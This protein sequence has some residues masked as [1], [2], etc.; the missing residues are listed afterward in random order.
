V[1]RKVLI[2][3]RGEIAL[4]VARA[5]RELG[6]P[7]VAVYSTV[8]SASAVVR[9][10]DEAIHVGPPPAKQSYLNVPNVI[11]AALKAGAD[12]IHPGYGFLSEDA[13]FAEICAD[14]GLTFIGPPPSVMRQVGDKAVVRAHMAAAGL[15]VVRGSEGVVGNLTDAAEAAAEIGFPLV[16]KATMGGGGRGIVR[17]D[18]PADLATGFTTTTATAQALFGDPGVYMEKF[19]ADAAH[20]EAQ[21]LADQHGNVHYLGERDCTMQRRNQKLVEES[22]SPRLSDAQRAQL[23]EYA[24]T[25]A[26]SLGYQGAGTL[27]FLADKAGNLTFMEINGRIQV[28]HPVSELV[29]G[30]DIVA[31]MIRGAGG[32]PLTYRP[33]QLATKGCAI[34][35]RINAE[36]PTRDFRPTPGVLTTF[37]PPAGPFVRV[38]SGYVQGDSVPAHYDSL[39]AKVLVHAPD[40]PTAIRR[41]V[42][43]LDE[44][45]VESPSVLTTIGLVRSLVQHPVFVAGE[46]T[47]AFVDR[48]MTEWRPASS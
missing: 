16:I 9:Y 38:D 11:E 3:N 18:D 45:R 21:I 46:H 48:F 44:F 20:V 12:S 10:A 47:T 35:V 2:A 27:E 31:D 13:D 15:P 26:R 30:I 37:Q 29:T 1:L 39:L 22:P 33:D 40:R 36:D 4:R 43:A 5:C 25:A 19:V 7:S 42:R 34:E 28:E 41:M 8:D 17:V 32:E 14:N 23:K 6:I 24:V